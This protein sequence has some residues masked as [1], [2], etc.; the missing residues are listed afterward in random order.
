MNKRIKASALIVTEHIGTRVYFNLDLNEED[1]TV[2]IVKADQPHL[3][4]TLQPLLDR[5]AL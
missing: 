1:G 4:E 5:P 2:S 3:Y